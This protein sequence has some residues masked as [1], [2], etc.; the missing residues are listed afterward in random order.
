MQ[1][2]KII[3][4]DLELD[5]KKGN[6]EWSVLYKWAV[7]INERNKIMP[8]TIIFKGIASVLILKALP[9]A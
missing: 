8:T 6:E 9:R 5:T 1:G 4:G 2:N 3:E 7:L